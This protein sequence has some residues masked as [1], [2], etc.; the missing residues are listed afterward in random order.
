MAVL[1]TFTAAVTDL[2]LP[3]A[4]AAGG[5]LRAVP[6]RDRRSA[7]V[8]HARLALGSWPA[9]AGARTP[10]PTC[11]PAPGADAALLPWGDL[12]LPPHTQRR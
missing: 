11:S 4:A 10:S 8:D 6:S 7:L 9:M 3:A 2:A 1:G 12:P 5:E